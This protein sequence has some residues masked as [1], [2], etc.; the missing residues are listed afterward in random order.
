MPIITISRQFG[1]GGSDV[2]ARIAGALGWTLLDNALVDAVAEQLG[3]TPQAI[4]AREERVPSLAERLAVAMTLG[5]PEFVPAIGATP[6]PPFEDRIVEVTRQVVQRAVAEGP[7][8]VV[9]RGA[10]AMLAERH[11]V[12]HVFCYAPRPALVERVMVRE[13]C[14]PSEAE[15]VVDE[16]NRQRE[17]YV[18]RH[19]HRS[20]L[21]HEHYHVCVNTDWLG[22]GGAAELVLRLARDKFGPVAEG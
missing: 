6:P 18:K 14:S 20:W 1:S 19:W 12:L 8:V 3:T 13:G 2:A 21:A 4:E 10:Q 22:I 15:R 7:V 17:H 5:T 16:T 11:D 9:G